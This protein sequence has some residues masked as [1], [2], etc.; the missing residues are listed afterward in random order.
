M[1]KHNEK[2]INELKQ[3][4]TEKQVLKYLTN[5]NI[6]IYK[7]NTY[8]SGYFNIWLDDSIRI[9]KNGKE[10]IVQAWNKYKTREVEKI[11]PNNENLEKII[12]T[13]IISQIF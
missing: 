3:C 4:K 11:I 9:Y 2:L 5:N 7:N 13:E 12:T 8:E 6:E 10:I 1:L